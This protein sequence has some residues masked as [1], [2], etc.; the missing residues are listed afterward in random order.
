MDRNTSGVTITLSG[1]YGILYSGTNVVG[2]FHIC[3]SADITDPMAIESNCNA[4]DSA[5]ITF[6]GG[7]DSDTSL[8]GDVTLADGEWLAWGTTSASS[9]GMFSA[10]IS[11]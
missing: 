4:V 11:E 7:E 1:V 8:N 10:C 2:Q 3:Q 6:N 9:P 5:D